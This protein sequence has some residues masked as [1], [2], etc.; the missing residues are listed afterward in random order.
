MESK[1]DLILHPVRIRI[2]QILFG[3]EMTT[4]EIATSTPDVPHATL[5][6]HLKLLVQGDIIPVVAENRVRG[7]IERVYAVA[8]DRAPITEE[9]LRHLDRD[10]HLRMFTAYI[11]SVIGGSSLTLVRAGSISR[12]TG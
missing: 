3:R 11:A 8:P 5:Y 10:D 12:R 9:D 1:V 7:A 6:R 4:E 2:I